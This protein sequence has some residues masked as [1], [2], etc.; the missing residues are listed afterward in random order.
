MAMSLKAA[1]FSKAAQTLSFVF[2]NIAG[3]IVTIN[4]PN[5]QVGGITWQEQG[6]KLNIQFGESPAAA[7]SASTTD[8]MN[9]VLT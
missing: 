5:V 1:A 6:A 2:G 3:Q 4:L 8:E 7:S 9:I